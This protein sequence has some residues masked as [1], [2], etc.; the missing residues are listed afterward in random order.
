MPF[1]AYN[2]AVRIALFD[3]CSNFHNKNY[4]FVMEPWLRRVG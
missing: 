1:A 3:T 2:L 4:V